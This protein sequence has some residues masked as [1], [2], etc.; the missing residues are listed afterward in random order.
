MGK[1]GN[2]VAKPH[3]VL[4][5]LLMAALLAECISLFY[6]LETDLLMTLGAMIL[7]VAVAIF[8]VKATFRVGGAWISSTFLQHLGDPLKKKTTMKKFTDQSWQLAIHASMTVLEIVVIMDETWWQDTRSMWNP[9]SVTCDF[10]TQKY[11]T[12]F[13]YITQLAIWI[14]TAFSCK[15]LEEIRKDYLVMMT[16]HVV[17]IALVSWSYAQGYLPVGVLILI[18]HD[19][20]DIPLDLLK[21][22]NYMKLEGASGLFITEGLFAIVLSVW[23][24]V[25][26]YLF[27]VKL[28]NSAFWENREA[29]MSPADAHDLSI[30]S[31]PGVPMWFGFNALLITLYVL[32]V[33]WGFLLVRL[34]AKVMTN[35][36]HDTAKD[37]YEGTSSDSEASKED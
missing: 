33:W 2:S 36:V 5:G 1:R 20:S 12:K 19:A 22:A 14:Y 4:D 13:L 9:E 3:P 34:L 25:R 26:I 16:H 8:A 11:L 35:S 37:E 32:H 10:P 15:F 18:V 28:I 30:L 6:I 27:P 17:T 24:Y 31:F 7:V 21:M 23:F 29:C